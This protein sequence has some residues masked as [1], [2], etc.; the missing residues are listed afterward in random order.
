MSIRWRTLTVPSPTLRGANVAVAEP[1]ICPKTQTVCH[2]RRACEALREDLD[3]PKLGEQSEDDR[4]HRLGLILQLNC[5][6]NVCIVDNALTAH[7]FIDLR[8]K[9]EKKL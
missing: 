6:N 5:V 8:E 4:V 9:V 3:I 1:G 2:Y 7:D